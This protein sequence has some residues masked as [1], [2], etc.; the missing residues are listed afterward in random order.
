MAHL[1][2]IGVDPGIVMGYEIARSPGTTRLTLE[3]WFNDTPAE[4]PAPAH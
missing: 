1:A 3:L 2:E 4:H